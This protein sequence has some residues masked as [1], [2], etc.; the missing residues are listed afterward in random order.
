MKEEMRESALDKGDGTHAVAQALLRQLTIAR[1]TELARIGRYSEA[2]GVLAAVDREI[3]SSPDM[4]DLLARMR[5]QQGRLAEAEKLWTRA[6]QLEP[7][8]SAF[9]DAL[10]RIA[11]TQRRS[12][13]RQLA[14]PLVVILGLAVVL[15]VMT[16]W[17]DR[18]GGQKQPTGAANTSAN[19]SPVETPRAPQTSD[20]PSVPVPQ[21]SVAGVKTE[22]ENEPNA[23][24]VTFDDGLFA[25]GAVLTPT[26]R[27]RLKELGLQLKDYADTGSIT[28]IGITD[29]SSVPLDSRYKDN[30]T[31]GME[32]ARAVYD[33]LR[34]TAGLGAYMF[35]ISSHGAQDPPYP[36][37]TL[38]NRTRN[39]TVMLRITGRRE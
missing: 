22:S 39:R 32:R 15:L 28:I 19:P 1:A 10:R 12:V 9:H 18:N 4:L 14:L 26:A 16:R 31:L 27:Q 34:T 2:E 36:N 13:R 29:D 37:D 35:T 6:N 30:A 24:R 21:I 38:A 17:L 7:S 23:L 11:S 8:N 20:S 5:A 25:R 33:Y 3:E